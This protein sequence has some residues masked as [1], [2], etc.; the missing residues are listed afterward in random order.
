MGDKCLSAIFIITGGK[1]EIFFAIAIIA[2][3]VNRYANK[4]EKECLHEEKKQAMFDRFEED[5]K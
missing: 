3:I 4:K 5:G 2:F 1:M